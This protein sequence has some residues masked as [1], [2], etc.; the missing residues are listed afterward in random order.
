LSIAESSGDVVL[1]LDMVADWSGRPSR[2][3]WL[4]EAYLTTN[5]IALLSKVTRL[6]DNFSK[7]QKVSNILKKLSDIQNDII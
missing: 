3:I 2:F 4:D 6:H 7:S 1:D 5:L